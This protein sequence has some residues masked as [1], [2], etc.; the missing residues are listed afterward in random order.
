MLYTLVYRCFTLCSDKTNFHREL[1][2]LKEVFQRNG[3]LASFID[4]C[5]KKFLDG[6]HIIKP[7]LQRIEKKS[8]SLVLLYFGPISLQVRT[9][10]RSAM[11]SKM[12]L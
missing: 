6:L 3:Y 9:K 4:E 12:A 2:T 8:L 11:K 1:V 10:V 5:F 7:T